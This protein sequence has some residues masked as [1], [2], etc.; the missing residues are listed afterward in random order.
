MRDI[1]TDDVANRG[2]E[3]FAGAVAVLV[4][5]G[6][7]GFVCRV[8]EAGAFVVA[9]VGGV[10]PVHADMKLEKTPASDGV[11]G[12]GCCAWDGC[13]SRTGD[14]A[15]DGLL[16][17]LFEVVADCREIVYRNSQIQAMRPSSTAARKVPLESILRS[18]TDSA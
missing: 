17:L 3:R 4:V 6:E 1:C 5:A 8:A 16:L 10:A 14:S 7:V 18:T 11:E 12:E 13:E 15:D 2:A 9:L